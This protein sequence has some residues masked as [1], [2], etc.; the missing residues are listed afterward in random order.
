MTFKD[1]V[2][3][4]TRVCPTVKSSTPDLKTTQ[5]KTMSGKEYVALRKSR[6]KKKKATEE[7][8]ESV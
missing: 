5:S 6:M 7:A 3:Y 8:H 4:A 1:M 2:E